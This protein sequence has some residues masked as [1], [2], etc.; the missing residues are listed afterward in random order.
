[1]GCRSKQLRQRTEDFEMTT[2]WLDRSLLQGPKL[3]LV[4]SQKEYDAALKEADLP[5]DDHD[6]CSAG[7]MA[8]THA[9]TDKERV[10][11]IG[12]HPDAIEADP[13]EVISVL[14]HE[15]VHVWQRT[16]DVS[17]GVTNGDWGRESDAYAIQNIAMTLIT[18]FK[19]RLK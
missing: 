4:M 2:K 3:A 9:W 19:R 15:A 7:C 13:L 1:M 10:C 17:I 5:A 14:I 16:T 6:F 12:L 8:V 18:E 11:I